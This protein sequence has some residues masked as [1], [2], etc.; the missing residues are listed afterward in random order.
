MDGNRDEESKLINFS[1]TSQ[2]DKIAF[3]GPFGVGKTTALNAISDVPVIQTEALSTELNEIQRKEG[4]KTTTVGMEYGL[5]HFPDGTRVDLVGVPGQERFSVVWD[6][7]LPRCTAVVVW[8][9]YESETL[10]NDAHQWLQM[11]QKRRAIERVAVGITRAPE[12][13]Q[14]RVLNMLRPIVAEYHPYAPVITADVRDPVQVMQAIMMALTTPY[15][16]PEK[17]A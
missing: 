5:L 7:L 8:L 13:G 12:S 3:V 4:K 6:I 17:V 14:D 1:H 16:T 9:S 2:E 11:L 15:Y 10:D